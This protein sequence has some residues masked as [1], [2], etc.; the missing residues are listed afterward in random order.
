MESDSA[1]RMVF[2]ESNTEKTVKSTN[3]L[4]LITRVVFA[5]LLGGVLGYGSGLLNPHECDISSRVKTERATTQFDTM[6]FDPRLKSPFTAIVAG[7]TGS[8]K[9]QLLSRLILASDEVTDKP[10]VEIIY[11][12]G[13]WQDGYNP[14]REYVRFHKGMINVSEEIPTDNR[15]RWLIID[16]LMEE[17]GSN[18]DTA[19]VYTKYSHHMNISVFMIVQN[20]FFGGRT[21][22]IN[23]QYFFLFKN[24]RDATGVKTLFT[25]MYPGR[26]HHAMEAYEDAT[27]E[28][29]G[30]LMV[31]LHQ[32]TPNN[33]RLVGN[34]G[35][36]NMSV[37]TEKSKTT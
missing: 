15:S 29:H 13:V 10:P 11:C 16:D 33:T 1:T 22:S 31:D 28:A 37:Y 7:P 23:S 14:L 4:P 24:P 26:W 8:G 6:E 34:Y 18:K 5:V 32:K 20:L 36:A 2:A 25:Q 12:Y 19:A 35:T 9:T 21:V 3:T 17:V 27:K 30:F